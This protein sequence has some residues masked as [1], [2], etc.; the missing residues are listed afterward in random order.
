[1]EV[2]RRLPEDGQVGVGVVNRPV[3][4]AAFAADELRAIARAA[5]RCRGVVAL[6]V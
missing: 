5:A 4:S 3:C 2:L 1:M 6:A